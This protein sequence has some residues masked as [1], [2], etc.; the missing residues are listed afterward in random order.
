MGV[1]TWTQDVFSIFDDIDLHLNF[2]MKQIWMT[3]EIVSWCKMS[4]HA[5]KKANWC[6]STPSFHLILDGNSESAFLLV[7]LNQRS[8]RKNVTLQQF[9]SFMT[10]GRQLDLS[11]EQDSVLQMKMPQSCVTNLCDLKS[12]LTQLFELLQL[13][14]H[15]FGFMMHTKSV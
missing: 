3:P 1:L 13:H 10:K 11:V 9:E 14:G 8:K 6:H 7:H 4:W 15:S 2:V 5:T 12:R